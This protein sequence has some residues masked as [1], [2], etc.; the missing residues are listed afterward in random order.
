MA[1]HTT[2]GT[3]VGK[4]ESYRWEKLV[5]PFLVHNILGPIPPPPSL[6]IVP[7]APPPP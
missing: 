7:C 5:G 4:S 3:I 1:V 2:E 6:L